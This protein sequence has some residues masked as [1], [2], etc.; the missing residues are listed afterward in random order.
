MVMFLI[1]H[2]DT[3]DLPIIELIEMV[4]NTPSHPNMFLLEHSDTQG[5]PIIEL[6]EMVENTAL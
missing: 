1:E 2:S 3:R 4:E 6:I 5:L